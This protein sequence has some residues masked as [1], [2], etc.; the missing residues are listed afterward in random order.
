MILTW[1]ENKIQFFILNILNIATNN[2]SNQV[3]KLFKEQLDV[4]L[5]SNN[6]FIKII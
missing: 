3:I 1:Y 2:Q 4:Y 5:P 6:N